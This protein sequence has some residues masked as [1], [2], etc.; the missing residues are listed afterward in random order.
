MLST[1]TTRNISC[2]PI[3]LF[4]RFENNIAPKNVFCYALVAEEHQRTK[5]TND[6]L[7]SSMRLVF[8]TSVGTLTSH[9]WEVSTTFVFGSF[10]KLLLSKI[11]HAKDR[12]KETRINDSEM[13]QNS[14]S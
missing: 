9:L 13:K 10:W 11:D 8:G 1:I 6:E 12:T 7:R 14:K 2:F 3:V 4:V 5:E